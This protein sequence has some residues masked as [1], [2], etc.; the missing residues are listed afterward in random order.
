MSSGYYIPGPPLS[1]YVDVVWIYERYAQPHAQQRLLPTGGMDLVIGLDEDGRMGSGVSGVRSEFALLDTSRPFSAIGVHFKPG[2]GFPFFA[3]PAGELQDLGVR[4]DALWGAFA[5][6][7]RDQLL[8]ADSFN[9]RFRILERALLEKSSGRLR[10]NPAVCYALNE[11]G[12]TSHAR[13]VAEVTD[14]VGLSARR[15]I[16]LFRNQVGLTPK[17]FCRIRRFQKVLRTVE[18]QRDVDWTNVALSCG[19]F[20]Q[21]HFIHDFRAFSGINPST[22]LRQRTSRNHVSV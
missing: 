18:K 6:D 4:L 21:A 10:R 7:L 17:V 22:Y 5:T 3:P 2:G 16:E 8:E 15:F 11:F 13:S 9:S 14:C 20:D 12:R 19:Y 1:D